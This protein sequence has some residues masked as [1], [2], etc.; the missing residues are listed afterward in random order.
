MSKTSTTSETPIFE[1]NYKRAEKILLDLLSI[2]GPSGEEAAVVKYIVDQLKAA[3]VPASAI[4]TDRAHKKSIF[5]GQIGNLA[6]RL[7]GNKRADRRLFM[8]HM[9][10]VP[11]CVGTKP[12]KKG[13]TI[14]PASRETGLGADNRSGV[15][16]VLA[17]ALDVLEKDLP[18]PPLTFFWT[19]QEEGGMHGCRNATISMLGKPKLA[20][21]MDA[22]H[23]QELTVGATSGYRMTIDIHGIA[24]HAGTH[25]DRGVSAITI[26]SLA[27][28]E[29]HRDGWI[30]LVEKN[31]KRGAANIGLINGGDA[32]NVVAPY[33]QLKAEARSHNAG[34]RRRIVSRIESAF[35]R[36][37][38]AVKSSEG[39]RGSVEIQGRLDYEAFRLKDKEPCVLEAEA[40]IRE[41]GGEPVKKVANG[42]LD[43]NWMAIH[44]IPTVTFGTGQFNA[45]TVDEWMD[46]EEYRKA[47]KLALRLATR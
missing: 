14:R 33:V 26:A 3:G 46:L 18:A 7:P 8:A 38:K 15:A 25:P 19:V 1:P 13:N 27:I 31:G 5:G 40:A 20:F 35:Q 34:L 9:D 16:T 23:W 28:A 39:K 22:S 11:I 2:P 42:G 43:A 36:A 30:G 29:L 4:K 37:A 44:E 21:N 17:T 45:H 41:L 32:I 12:V 10:T 24:S 47:C 6:C